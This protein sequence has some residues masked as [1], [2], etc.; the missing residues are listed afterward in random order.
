MIVEFIGS[1]GAGKTTLADM[2]RERIG[3]E[4]RVLSSAEM[5]LNRPGRRWIGNPI[6]M[7]LVADATSLLPLIRTW[8]RHRDFVRFAFRRIQRHAPSAFAKY[9][10]MRNVVRAVGIHELSR[11]VGKGEMILAD[12]G[13]VLTAYFL[14]VYSMASFTQDDL[15]EF[16]ALVPLPERVVYVRAPVDV[17]VDRA[18]NRPDRRREFTGASRAEVEHWISRSTLVF[19]GVASAPAIR[20][21]LLIVGG[22]L[23]GPRDLDKVVSQIASFIQEGIPS[24]H[25]E[26]ARPMLRRSR[27]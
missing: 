19:E 8:S 16:A 7:N 6:A 15:D 21:R 26:T 3:S 25:G 14:F 10:Y 20:D 24:G 9:N 5:Y 4:N 17:L 23:D 22:A 27:S 13:T 12:E 1:S 2:L 11:R 18:M